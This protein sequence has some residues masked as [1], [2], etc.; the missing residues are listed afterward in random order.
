MSFR[1]N[2]KN[3]KDFDL[4]FNRNELNNDINVR[5][6]ISSIN[7]SIRNILLTF[8]GERPFS[9]LGAGLNLYFFDNDDITA[10]I[11]AKD[12][13]VYSLGK[14]EPRIKVTENDISFERLSSGEIAINITYAIR[15]DLGLGLQQNVTVVLTEE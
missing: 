8:S 11:G 14:Y 3:Y 5:S 15:E 1:P 10:I 4:Q 7:Q 13:I 12:A 2:L 9:D 6:E